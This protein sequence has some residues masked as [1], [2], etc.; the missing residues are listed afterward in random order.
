MIFTETKLKG[1]FIID[2]K[3]F[4]DERGWFAR[5]FCKNEFKQIGHDA[6]WVQLNHSVTNTKGTIR[7]MHFQH[8]PF[9]EIKLVRCIKGSV[10]DVIIDLREGSP[11]FLQWVGEEL[12]ADNKKMFYIPAGFAHGFQTLKDDS[13]LIYHHSAFYTPGVEGGIRFDDK[14]INIEWKLPVSVISDRDKNHPLIYDTFNGI[15]F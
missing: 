12:S 15:K 11:T 10:Y 2:L 3:I 14:K 13:Q 8:P 5:T 7:G 1:S 6:E 4:S 9:S